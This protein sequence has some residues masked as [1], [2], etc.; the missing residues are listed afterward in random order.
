MMPETL[1]E[2][3]SIAP[4]P[5]ISAFIGVS[6]Q[7]DSKL[8]EE[9]TRLHPARVQANGCKVRFLAGLLVRLHST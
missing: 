9:R 8:T 5:P 4:S 7:N 1:S 3:S 6:V 2:G